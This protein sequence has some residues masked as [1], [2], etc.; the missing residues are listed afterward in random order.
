MA[1]WGR[2]RS[3]DIE[4]RGRPPASK[5]TR[6][7]DRTET[8]STT[9]LAREAVDLENAAREA[10]YRLEVLTTL[11]DVLA[12]TGSEIRRHVDRLTA[13][14]RELDRRLGGDR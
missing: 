12:T 14:F 6:A 8:P 5:A 7:D 10:A 3:R 13:D 11:A 2:N 1:P 4:G 9:I